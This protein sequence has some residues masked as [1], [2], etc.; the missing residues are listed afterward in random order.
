[1]EHTRVYTLSNN[2]LALDQLLSVFVVFKFNLDV[3]LTHRLHLEM[4]AIV[5]G[6]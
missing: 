5:A 3:V 6:K 1:M 4:K 2:H